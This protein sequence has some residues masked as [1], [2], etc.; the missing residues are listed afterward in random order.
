MKRNE[1]AFRKSSIE[2]DLYVPTLQQTPV[3]AALEAAHAT[4]AYLSEVELVRAIAFGHD[5]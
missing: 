5:P 4:C 1:V 3:F 2:P